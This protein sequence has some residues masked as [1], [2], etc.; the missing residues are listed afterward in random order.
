MRRGATPQWEENK[1]EV[2]NENRTV[3]QTEFLLPKFSAEFWG[4]VFVI[5]CVGRTEID[6]K[7]DHCGVCLL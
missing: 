4:L 3:A 5:S 7:S 1:A 6:R 2:E